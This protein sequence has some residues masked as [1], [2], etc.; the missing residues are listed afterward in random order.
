V[1]LG[2]L[3]PVTAAPL[4]DAGLTPYHAVKRSLSL[5]LPGSTAVVIGVG[6]LGHLAI[7]I[8]KALSPAQ[9]IAIDPRPEALALAR[10][11][12]AHHAVE[13]GT[14]AV[15]AVRD[16]TGGLGADLVLDF[17]GSAASLASASA[18]TRVLGHLTIVGLGGG[19]AT[20]GAFALPWEVSVATTYWGSRSELMEVLA[21]A[22][23]GL[24]RAEVSTVPLA[25]APRAYDDLAAGRVTGRLVVAP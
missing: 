25:D 24:V 12:G 2:D 23:A 4:T 5:L 20:V 17:V 19:F 3:D 15:D 22:R 10:A 14:S 1:P 16:L 11:V 7:Q 13:A 9:V 6:G 18:M 21:L 8:V